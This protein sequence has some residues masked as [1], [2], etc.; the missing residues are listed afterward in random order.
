MY[1]LVATSFFASKQKPNIE[2]FS[3]LPLMLSSVLVVEFLGDFIL[4]KTV[5]ILLIYTIW[6]K[7]TL[8]G[9]W[10]PCIFVSMF[11]NA[12]IYIADTCFVLAASSFSKYGQTLFM[13]SPQAFYLFSYLAKC[14]EIIMII[15]VRSLLRKRHSDKPNI[16]QDWLRTS[17]LPTSTLLL[18]FVFLKIFYSVPA[19]ATE[20]LLCAFIL[21]F[22]NFIS[23]FI[24]EK[25]DERQEI[26]HRLPKE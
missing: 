11:F 26:L 18:C 4:V 1:Y 19:L 21:L 14:L 7:I 5:V 13:N 10:I 23:A 20:L 17:I 24:V 25:L 2:Y 22:T 8:T 16:W 6:A 12:F 3:L 9:S 15:T